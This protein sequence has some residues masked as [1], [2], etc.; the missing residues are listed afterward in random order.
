MQYEELVYNKPNLVKMIWK[1]L[2]Q[3]ASVTPLSLVLLTFPKWQ[4]HRRHSNQQQLLKPYRNITF[5]ATCRRPAVLSSNSWLYINWKENCTWKTIL[6][7]WALCSFS[8]ENS[9]V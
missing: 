7:Q 3:T 8:K 1:G 5:S 6:F 2:L 9:M 4:K